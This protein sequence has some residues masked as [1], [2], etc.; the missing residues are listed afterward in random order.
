MHQ[1]SD[2][3]PSKDWFVKDS[4]LFT[5]PLQTPPPHSFEP[6]H[7]TVLPPLYDTGFG[8]REIARL[9]INGEFTFPPHA[10]RQRD[11]PTMIASL[12]MGGGASHH[13]SPVLELG[14]YGLL[15]FL[16][17]MQ[18]FIMPGLPMAIARLAGLLEADPMVSRRNFRLSLQSLSF[19]R[20]LLREE[21]LVAV[22]RLC[23]KSLS[24]LNNVSPDCVT[25]SDN[26]G[27]GDDDDDDV[28]GYFP[29]TAS[30]GG[31]FSSVVGPCR[32]LHEFQN[33]SMFAGRMGFACFVQF[34]KVRGDKLVKIHLS[35]APVFDLT[36]IVLLR[37]YAPNLEI[38]EGTFVIR[39]NEEGSH[40]RKHQ[41]NPGDLGELFIQARA[42]PF[43]KE[44]RSALASCPLKRLRSVDIEGRI[45]LLSLQLLAGNADNLEELHLTNSP[46]L[47][48]GDSKALSDD[49]IDGLLRVNRLSNVRS[50]TLRMDSLQTA[51][52][53][54]LTERGL[55]MLLDHFLEHCH[56]IGEVVGEFTRIPDTKLA[57]FN[58]KYVE[59]GLRRLSVRN[60]VPY[61]RFDNDYDSDRHYGVNEGY[62]AMIQL[63]QEAAASAAAAAAAAA[64]GGGGGGNQQQQH[65]S[66]W[67]GN[68]DP[69]GM[70]ADAGK[71]HRRFKGYVFRPFDK[72]DCEGEERAGQQGA[73][74]R[75][76]V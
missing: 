72:G 70:Y 12:K 62:R 33:L 52:C 32:C 53:G 49:W 56:K 27:G 67:R 68:G 24:E 23:G 3:G 76:V 42:S 73:R 6:T 31:D 39:T 9:R 13:Q 37:T 2:F 36:D 38:L 34:A 54:T 28:G 71:R 69:G 4:L 66:W 14:I 58:A 5:H 35:S 75:H 19:D 64:A 10:A 8:C 47:V 63:Q 17:K 40:V 30:G 22:A 55:V 25:P 15:L 50:L 41:N 16:K 57:A 46:P 48:G 59:L 44:V 65:H 29:P 26:G 51:D 60:A 61:R 18:R 1:L 20:D 45:T 11:S 7:D 21:E 43:S 74:R